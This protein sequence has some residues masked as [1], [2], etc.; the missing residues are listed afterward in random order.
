MQF[1]ISECSNI[2]LSLYVKCFGTGL[3]CISMFL[4]ASSCN[5]CLFIVKFCC[6]MKNPYVKI[7]NTS[8]VHN[9]IFDSFFVNLF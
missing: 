6:N 4:V 2:I 5:L 9:E 8:Q 7:H 3:L 1:V